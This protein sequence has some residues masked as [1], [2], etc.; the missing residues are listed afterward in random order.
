[1]LERVERLSE[2]REGSKLRLSASGRGGR[3]KSRV[4]VEFFLSNGRCQKVME[5]KAAAAAA[6]RPRPRI[7]NLKLACDEMDND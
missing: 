3:I 2:V 6:A 1:M 7:C 5:S 4:L